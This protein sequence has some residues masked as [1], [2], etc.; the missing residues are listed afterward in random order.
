MKKLLILIIAIGTFACGNNNNNI[1]KTNTKLSGELTNYKG[2]VVVLERLETNQ[3]VME[4]TLNVNESGEFEYYLNAD[5]PSFYRV[6]LG[7]NNF[8]NVIISPKDQ[9]TLKADANNLEATVQVDG[10]SESS[11]LLRLNELLSASYKSLDSI[12]QVLQQFQASGNVQ[13]YQA[14][15]QQQFAISMNAQEIIKGF[16]D[17]NPASMASL[18]A[19]QNLNPDQDFNYYQKVA[20]GLA[21]SA[22]GSSYY[23]DLKAKVDAYKK[24]AVG[25]EAPDIALENPNGEVV[26]LSSLRGNVVLIDFWASWCKPCRMEN[27][28]VVRMYKQYNPKGFEIYGVSLDKSRDAWLKAI[29]QDGLTWTHVSD[30]QFWQSAG[31]KLY[32]VTAIPKTFLIDKDGTIIGKDLRGASLESKLEEIFSQG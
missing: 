25:S 23:E 18:A 24:L 27:P 3:I 20:E 13:G 29:E 31:A 2:G 8:T 28:N 22:A 12:R 7:Q 26:K 21:T 30:L 4:D 19:V 5:F 16:I 10:S 14:A 6:R 15:Y 17:E 32:N 1:V 9:V 11:R